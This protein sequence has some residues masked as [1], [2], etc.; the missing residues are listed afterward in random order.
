MSTQEPERPPD[1]TDKRTL[2]V[3]NGPLRLVT[4]LG[5]PQRERALLG[6]LCATG[7]FVVVRRCLAAEQLYE[8]VVQQAPDAALVDGTL[9]RLGQ[10]TLIHLAQAGVPVVVLASG[11]M[12]ERYQAHAAGVLPADVE[13]EELRQAIGQLVRE[14][15][16]H[17]GPG[18]ASRLG[19][20]RVTHPP[21]S[22]TAD[23]A[24]VESIS[25][26]QQDE[27][28][29]LT[30][31]GIHIGEVLVIAGG[32]GAP[33]RTTVAV[34]LATALGAIEP[35]VLIDAD[36]S[37]PSVAAFVDA[38]P[39]RNIAMLAHAAPTLS[40][41]WAG[42]IEQELQPLGPR[43]PHGRL[44]CG[45]PR[46]EMRTVIA[47]PFFERLLNE[48]R[49]RYRY[50]VVDVGDD[51]IDAPIHRVALTLATRV[52]LVAAAESIGV[53]HA[54]EALRIFATHLGLPVADAPVGPFADDGEARVSLVVNRYDRRYHHTPAEIAWALGTP[55]A[56]VLPHDY[57]AAQRAIDAQQPLV[58]DSRSRAGRALLDLAGRIHRGRIV[59]SPEPREGLKGG[60]GAWARLPQWLSA[61][62]RCV[63]RPPVSVPASAH[64]R[65]LA[66]QPT[67]TP[68]YATTP[69]V[70]PPTT[71]QPAPRMTKEHVA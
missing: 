10:E 32:H 3:P 44:L 15:K 40:E 33:G 55:V 19:A 9:H 11:D 4:G 13:I 50:V 63:L 14:T 7:E 30:A 20:G 5:D 12:T 68:A 31:E 17:A 43:S 2:T 53:W 52:L 66:E 67:L 58:L 1:A 62:F 45:V 39:T 36:M 24:P 64:A 18:S 28:L 69:V 46:A 56:V 60:R 21:A 6:A 61:T 59:L 25:L 26:S 70:Q 38:D 48:L 16:R 37:S 65:L 8:A 35:T 47:P 57:R 54:R 23:S 42:A 71:P 29:S 49:H 27:Y 22:A 41:A 34:S 51:L